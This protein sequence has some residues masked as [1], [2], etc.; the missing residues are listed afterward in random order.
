MGLEFKDYI[1]QLHGIAFPNKR[2]GGNAA[3]DSMEKEDLSMD[4]ASCLSRTNGSFRPRYVPTRHYY[5]G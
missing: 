3:L 1:G 5:T 4:S 2:G